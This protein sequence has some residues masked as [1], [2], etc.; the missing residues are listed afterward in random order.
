[1]TEYDTIIQRK[2]V[3]ANS[4]RIKA[5]NILAKIIAFSASHYDLINYTGKPLGRLRF[6]GENAFILYSIKELR[7]REQLAIRSEFYLKR[8]KIVS[9]INGALDITLDEIPTR[10]KNR[11]KNLANL[12]A[13]RRVKKLAER[14][15]RGSNNLLNIEWEI[16]N[17]LKRNIKCN[18]NL[19]DN[20]DTIFYRNYGSVK[21]LAFAFNIINMIIGIPA[22]LVE[23]YVMVR[24]EE[25][26]SIKRYFWSEIWTKNGWI[27]VDPCNGVIIDPEDRF[28]IPIKIIFTKNVKDIETKYKLVKQTLR[29]AIIVIEESIKINIRVNSGFCVGT[30][31]LVSSR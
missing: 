6:N 20:P 7:P 31:D 12:Y 9:N 23:G 16:L 24:R 25:Y 22:R 18:E 1:M 5:V 17:F 14:I 19:E 2:Y 3:I 28:W 4:S 11:I 29:R 10:L 26:S 13:S 15:V 30:L 21:D 27:P 8:K